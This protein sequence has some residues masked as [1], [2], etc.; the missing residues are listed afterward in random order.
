MLFRSVILGRTGKN[1]AAGMS[2]G[3]DYV[4]DT[5]HTLYRRMNKDMDSLLE[6]T[7]KYDIAELKEILKD[8]EKETGS[9]LAA[10]ILA[11]FNNRVCEFK[12]VLPND[13]QKMLT[14]ISKY[15]EQGISHDNAVLEAFE[16]VTA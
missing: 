8:Y 2:G 7:D 6:V 10:E 14:A 15:E 4:L 3:V 16:E 13:Y 12:K 1:F 9:A 11:D 5:D